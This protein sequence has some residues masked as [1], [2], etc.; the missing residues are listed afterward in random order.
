MKKRISIIVVAICLF[1]VAT[2]TVACS[3]S[4]DRYRLLVW[5]PA[6]EQEMLLSMSES[7]LYENP[8]FA[9]LV[10]F[11]FVTMD[12]P[13]VPDEVIRDAMSAANIFKFPSGAIPAMGGNLLPMI[14]Q[15]ILTNAESRHVEAALDALWSD[16]TIG[17]QNRRAL[18]ALPA[19]PNNFVLHYNSDLLTE[20]DVRSIES[21]MAADIDAEFN[22]AMPLANAWYNKVFFLG[23]GATV[24]VNLETDTLQTTFAGEY[25]M[26]AAEYMSGLARHPLFLNDDGGQ[27]G[28][29]FRS[30]NLGAFF[31]PP[32]SRNDVINIPGNI[33]EGSVINA[34]NYA[35]A[36]LPTIRINSEDR[37]L[38]DF[39][40]HRVYGINALTGAS[41]DHLEAAQITRIAQLFVD[42]ITNDINQLRRFE[43][44][45]AAPTARTLVNHNQTNI[46]H[47]A[48]AGNP[49]AGNPG[50]PEIV[51]SIIQAQINSAMPMPATR[52]LSNFWSPQAVF[53]QQIVN[54]ADSGTPP[55][56]ADFQRWLD[57]LYNGI[58]INL[59]A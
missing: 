4:D 34:A 7:F 27:G 47:P 35:S 3:S 50:R 12:F 8:E 54:N 14:Y 41:R 48:I 36:P 10:R 39:S 6:E 49:S 43:L 5:A 28:Q 32:I 42:Y 37:Q 26:K 56:V 13:N 25:G 18:V 45:S 11:E 59:T 44:T 16:V 20:E 1:F 23:A 40:E 15:P 30:G 19:S 22:L 17:G 46:P 21:I 9:E 38:I 55:A 31:G 52:A 29:E 33:T 2:I 58:T 24:T 51:S 57:D 53:G